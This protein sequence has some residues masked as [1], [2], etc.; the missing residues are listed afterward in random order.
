[1]KTSYGTLLYTPYSLY[2]H[3]WTSS[4]VSFPCSLAT[5]VIQ[6]KKNVIANACVATVHVITTAMAATRPI[7]TGDASISCLI[8]E[9]DNVAALIDSIKDKYFWHWI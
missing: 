1:M 2:K 4:K 9:S 3:I 5:S 7:V 6:L 8:I